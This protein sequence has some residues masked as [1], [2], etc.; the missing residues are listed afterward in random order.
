MS[1][2]RKAVLASLSEGRVH[3]R[4]RARARAPRAAESR[5]TKGRR[6]DQDALSAYVHLPFC[7]RKCFYCDFPVV[8]LGKESSGT[9]Q[10][11]SYVNVLCKEIRSYAAVDGRRREE[12]AVAG[13]PLKTVFFGGGTPSLIPPAELERVL[14]TIEETFGIDS[15]AEISMEADPGTFDRQK[16]S[17]F[18]GLGV[19]RLSMGVQSFDSKLLELC[20][21]SHSLEDVYQAIE[22][23]HAVSPPSWSM[24]LMFGL[25]HQNRETWQNTLEQAIEAEPDHISCYDLQIEDGTPFAKW[26]DVG[27]KPLPEEDTGAEFFKLASEALSR[28]GYLHY[29]ISNYAKKGHESKHNITYW[30]NKPFYAFG[31]LGLRFLLLIFFIFPFTSNAQTNNCFLIH[32]SFHQVWVL[33]ATC[34]R[35]GFSV[36]AKC[37]NTRPG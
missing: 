26:Y 16:L 19:N 30:H 32:F 10:F 11:E 22:D 25:P 31:G 33:Q 2:L 17:D 13:E 36:H 4:A 14:A 3:A 6:K 37:V 12:E 24:D 27:L 1:A 28:S 23:M 9:T 21:R 15:N 18:V 34:T 8:A 29:E 20:G 5:A 35:Q 7:R